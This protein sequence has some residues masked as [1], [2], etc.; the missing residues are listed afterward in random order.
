LAG[1]K[2]ATIIVAI[3]PSKRATARKD[4]NAQ[5]GE[6]GQQKYPPYNL[7]NTYL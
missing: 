5:R 7:K 6:H 2:R 1:T 3:V 4:K